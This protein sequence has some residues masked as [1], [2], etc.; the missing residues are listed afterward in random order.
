V[1]THTEVAA[2]VPRADHTLHLSMLGLVRVVVLRRSLICVAVV[3][4]LLA[5]LL[6]L[7][8]VTG[9]FPLSFSRVVATLQGHGTAAEEFIVYGLRLP[10][11]LT[12]VL[13]GAALGASGAV[14]QSVT[15]NPLGSPDIIG[16]TY[17]A[18]FAAV[19]AIVVLDQSDS[20]VTL[21]ALCGGLG[22]AVLVYVLSY[23]GGVTG[24][25]LILVGIGISGVL[26][27]LVSYLLMKGQII[28][29]QEAYVWLT[30]SLNG[31]DWTDVQIALLGLLVLGP[32]L[33]GL[34][35]GLRMSEMGDD[36][37]LGLGVHVARN[38][39]LALAFGAALCAVAVVSAGP[40][41][42]IAL[43]AP[44]IARR[45]TGAPTVQVIPSMAIGALLLLASD[46][47][48]QRVVPTV[49]L[50]VG[51]TTLVL[52]GAYLAWLIAREGRSRIG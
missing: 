40:I 16:F 52:G 7:Q 28:D 14:Y 50:P 49:Q 26:A 20:G 37:A 34:G 45:L 1:T 38:R 15:R 47:V 33:V 6:L 32:V 8:L 29:A 42:F 4:L 35:P 27:S 46:A 2:Q 18:S 48:A 13:A 19:F 31:R 3:L 17:G 11:M 22:V 39:L 5:G 12:A 21:A 10:R 23:R 44:Q 43:A 25:R 9:D 41:T 36:A 24:Y 30:G 51:I